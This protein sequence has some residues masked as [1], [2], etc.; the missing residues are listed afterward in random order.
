M[1]ADPGARSWSEP[2]RVLRRLEWLAGGYGVLAAGWMLVGRRSVGGALVLTLA[3]A[4]SIVAFRGLQGLVIRLA[5]GRTDTR[6]PIDRRSR[7]LVWL[8]FSL[9]TLAPLVSLWMDS[10]RALGLVIGFSVLPLAVL[11]EGLLQL[12]HVVV[13]RNHGG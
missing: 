7:R 10:E 9:L 12:G 3:A 11:T 6:T 8:R 1:T 5:A 13:A 4:A 2:A